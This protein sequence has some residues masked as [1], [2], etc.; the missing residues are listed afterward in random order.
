MRGRL[1]VYSGAVEAVSGE[2][3]DLRGVDQSGAE[4]DLQG[5]PAAAGLLSRS[6]RS[7]AR[8]IEAAD[9]LPVSS[10]SRRDQDVSGSL[11]LS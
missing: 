10:M 1:T 4:A 3:D 11:Q 5:E 2:D 8:G 9:V 7:V 6:S